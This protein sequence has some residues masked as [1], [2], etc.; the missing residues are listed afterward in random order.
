VTPSLISKA[1]TTLQRQVR[2]IH[3]T[4][5]RYG[6]ASSLVF[7]TINLNTHGWSLERRTWSTISVSVL[8]CPGCAT[9]RSTCL[10]ESK[11]CN[12]ELEFTC[13]CLLPADEN[14]RVSYLGEFGPTFQRLRRHLIA[15]RAMGGETME[16]T[17]TMA[18]SGEVHSFSVASPFPHTYIVPPD[19]REFVVGVAPVTN[20]P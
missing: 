9:S 14:H 11:L 12:S 6:I 20:Q 1:S 5:Q 17:I 19:S 7:Y 13:A 3:G 4:F 2:H 18:A 8:H 10:I 15:I 16:R